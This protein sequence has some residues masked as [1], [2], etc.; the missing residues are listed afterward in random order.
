[1]KKYII[2]LICFYSINFFS[3]ELK[4]TGLNN[5]YNKNQEI[6]YSLFNN[7]NKKIIYFVGIEK[8]KKEWREIISDIENPISKTSSYLNLEPNKLI[9]KK[10]NISNL[11]ILKNSKTDN[12][13]RILIVYEFQN[14]TVMRSFHSKSFIIKK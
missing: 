9:K 10:I 13:Y 12:L 5:F 14:D 4:I 7:S 11:T 8:F 1:M 6:K 3:Q 2:I